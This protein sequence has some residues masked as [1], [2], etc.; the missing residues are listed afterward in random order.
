MR[1]A[2][3]H[4]LCC[5]RCHGDLAL[6]AQVREGEHV[7]EG[8]LRCPSCERTWPISRGVPRF[9]GIEGD[10]E[11]DL[12]RT[13][14]NFG[15]SWKIWR[16]IDDQR[17]PRQFLEWLTPLEAQDFRGR[18]VL[19]AGCG[20]GRHLRAMAG[21]GAAEVVGLDLS[22]AVDVAF[23][24]TRD[25]P[26][27]HVLQADMLRPPLRGGYD[28]ACSVGVLHHTPDPAESFGALRAQVRPGGTVAC[29]VYGRE[30]N[31]WIVTLV[32]PL[33][34]AVTRHLPAWAVRALAWVAA[35]L[36]LLVIHVLYVPGR[37]LGVRLFYGDYLLHLRTLGF[38]ECRHI[39]YD[40][41]IAPIAHYL[42]RHEVDRWLQREHLEQRSLSW[43][44]RNSWAGVG[45]VP[46]A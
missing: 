7:M 19:D 39:V 13:A 35:L 25:L 44:H 20:K 31:G 17:Y 21:F 2:L 5:P 11:G 28:M 9:V 23:E 37:A 18:R 43:V 29:W 40:H 34:L 45:V 12:G 22:D 24:N 32:N 30:N 42:P 26:E 41:L 10:L 4:H 46:P 36:L 6:G 14:R 38:R 8:A 27:V 16:H 1:D 3:R 15:R 33:R